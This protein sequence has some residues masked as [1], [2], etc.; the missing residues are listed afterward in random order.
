[1]RLFES[2]PI[3]PLAASFAG[4]IVAASWISAPALVF[5]AVAAMV[6]LL[7]VVALGCAYARLAALLLLAGVGSLGMLRG[8]APALPPDHIARQRL[9]SVVSIEGRVSQ[10]P[11]RWDADRVRVLLDVD[12]YHEGS[13]RRPAQGRVQLTIYGE[14]EPLGEGQRIRAEVRLH[15]PIGFSNPG[16]FDYPAHLRREGIL[17]VGS[18]RGDRVAPLTSD[19][20][21][22]PLRMK[23]WAVATIRSQ[24]PES[25]AAL[26]SGLLLGERTALPAETDEAF[27]RA[28]VY[29]VLA[30]SGFNVALV[31]SSV[32][33]SLALLGVPRRA[34]ALV[35]GVV[36]VG[37]ALVVGGQPSVVRATAM[38]LLLLLSVLLERDSQVMNA[39]CLSGL[40]L[41]AWRPTDLWDPGF[42]LSFAATAGIIYLAAPMTSFLENHRLP[43]WLAAALAVSLAAQLPV[44]PIMLAHF[45]QLSLIGVAANLLVV[46]L[47][48]PATTLGMLALLVHLVSEAAASLLFNTLW[49]LLIALRLVVWAAAAVPGAMVHLPAPSAAAVIAWCGALV[50]L[51]YLGARAWTRILASALAA[52]ALG[53]S[54]WPWVS[55]GDGRLRVTFL[56]VGQGDATFVELPEGPRLLVDGGPGGARRFDVGERVLCPFLWNRPVHGLDVVALSHTDADHAGGLAAVLRNFPVREFWESG[57]WGAGGQD[58]WLALGSSHAARRI[59]RDGQRLWVGNALVTVLNPDGQPSP[60]PNDDSL[61][62]R[63]DW[64]G[65][66]ILLTGDL[67]ALGEGR[68]LERAA[69]VRVLVLKVAHHGSRSSSSAAFLESSQ[70]SF[71]IVS[72]GARNPFRHP[73]PEALERLR[74]I[75]G[76]VYRTDRDGAIIFET[77]GARLWVTRWARATTEVFDLDPETRS[78]GSRGAA[79]AIEPNDLGP[80]AP[81]F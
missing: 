53:L 66:S 62:L 28:G 77:D 34:T 20:P 41:L 38:G 1:M 73:T 5:V 2:A 11:N 13:D 36:L 44:T 40:I 79:L 64:R 76:R 80:S 52:A 35:A 8:S 72:V 31:A 4:G 74:A 22:W 58:T 3:L 9:P 48:G 29:H 17:L 65:V 81:I 21:P 57:R 49:V 26:L 56:D 15:R 61:V 16:A 67:G 43:H 37:F 54:V 51:P 14:T 10:E 70:P 63:L 32:F 50:L 71:A 78:E 18:G 23:R 24:L 7:A 59:L 12:A 27:R 39:L 75:G 30:V 45:N 68:V 46:P 69:P 60:H 6:L 42:Q 19:A 55:P 25:S 33:A 47:A